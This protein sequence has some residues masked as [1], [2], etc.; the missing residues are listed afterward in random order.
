M[1]YNKKN[2][3]KQHSESC[4]ITN[5]K[6]M[7]LDS[8]I[9]LVIV[10]SPS[11]CK[12]IEEYL[13]EGYKV[14]ASFGHL[15]ELSSL[16]N[17]DVENNFNLTFETINDSKKKKHL[18]VLREH[19]KKASE[20]ILAT[21]N[22]REG[23]SI[24]WHICM[25]FNLP[26]ESTK[27]I[28]FNEITKTAI[29]Y[30]ISNPRHVD[31]HLVH[32]QQTRQ[33]LD[34]LIGFTVTPLLWKYISKNSENSLSA[35]RCQTPALKLIYDNQTKINNADE[36]KVYNVT[37]YF[38]NH[39]IPFTLNR[40]FEIRHDV[41]TDAATTNAD[42]DGNEVNEFLEQSINY[43]HLYSCSE[44]LKIEKKPPT[45][46]TTSKI[47]QLASNVMHIS[48][49]ETMK[50]C[51]VLYEDGYITY[52]RT[53]NAIYSN[54]FIENAKKYI[55]LNYQTNSSSGYI[56]PCI[57]LICAD[58]NNESSAHEAIRP[59]NIFVTSL[60]ESEKS[61]HSAKEKRLYKL[62]WETSI[63]SCM[64][65]SEYYSI[66]GNITAPKNMNYT[67]TIEKVSFMGWEIV[68]RDQNVTKKSEYNYMQSITQ[69]SILPYKKIITTTAIT[70]TK[71]H[72]TEA[73]LV[74]LLEDEGIGRPSTFSM[75]IDK[76]QQRG[77][78]NKQDVCGK[79]TDCVDYI[80]ESKTISKESTT[81]ETGSE[82]SK[83]VIQP[84][85]IIVV[86]FLE[87]NFHK[88][89]D[90]E[91]TKNMESYLDTISRGEVD[92]IPICK[93]CNDE[94]KEL[95]A[96]VDENET[97]KR[98]EI[99]IDEL[100]TYMIGKYGPVIKCSMIG[101]D[102]KEYTEFKSVNNN[103][104]VHKL[105]RGE[106]TLEEIISPLTVNTSRYI[107]KYKEMDLYIKKGR[108]GLYA[109]WGK[110][111]KSLSSLGNRPLDN[112]NYEDVIDILDSSKT[113]NQYQRQPKKYI[114]NIYKKR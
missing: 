104:D 68:K 11:K 85:G 87:K 90:Y 94:L 70:N 24:A 40:Q 28:V 83:L 44:P 88:I 110:D 59:T 111:K 106:Y 89:F 8:G 113:S 17:I 112:I 107:G 101:K 15:R 45:P 64:S 39:N 92:W 97:T 67:H 93:T 52:M 41:A 98:H 50:I 12:K 82:K 114:P 2:T 69:N 47:Q 19:C 65:S 60:E 61:K 72:Y 10:E 48:P 35:G 25:V 96:I 20:I 71:S 108:F 81:R 95:C 56:N 91:Y 23:E 73:R 18:E 13:G 31:I 100:H 75:I 57:E 3:Q 86:E 27:R 29:E 33:I 79:K 63:E 53:D 22:D 16:K 9:K 4:I 55:N 46:L 14:V 36:K 5:D 54:E 26:I 7:C 21:D 51:Q 58:T 84:L 42:D 34:L 1:K 76:I 38:T 80:L 74:Q 6:N 32:S 103:I 66:I 109:D 30:A 105:E 49:S 77:Y 43:P 62:I 102:G 78:V 99:K 37:G